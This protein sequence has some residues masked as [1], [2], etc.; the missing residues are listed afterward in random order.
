VYAGVL[1]DHLGAD[2]PKILAGN[3]EP[4]ALMAGTA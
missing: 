3:F 4:V 2:A 1:R